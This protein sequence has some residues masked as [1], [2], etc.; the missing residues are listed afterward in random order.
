MPSFFYI[1]AAFY[2]KLRP[3]LARRYWSCPAYVPVSQLIYAA[4][5]SKAKELLP[6]SDEFLRLGL[7]NPL[8]YWNIAPSAFR[9]IPH[10]SHQI[11]SALIGLKNVS[12][13]EFS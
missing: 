10:R 13:M 8:I 12:T 3:V 11:S 6:P 9:L 4:F 1:C 2:L 5:R 7:E